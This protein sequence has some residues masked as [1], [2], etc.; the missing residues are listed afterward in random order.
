MMQVLHAAQGLADPVMRG[1]TAA[2]TGAILMTAS[3]ILNE[4]TY[5]CIRPSDHVLACCMALGLL[6]T[7][8]WLHKRVNDSGWAMLTFFVVLLAAGGYL[9]YRISVTH[10]G[11]PNPYHCRLIWA[12]EESCPIPEP[13]VGLNE[14]RTVAEL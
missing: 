9:K 5:V 8:M 13:P 2:G 4:L 14:L 12:L 1:V 6:V 7:E 10:P 11:S 3:V